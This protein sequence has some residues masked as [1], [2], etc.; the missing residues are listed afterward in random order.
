MEFLRRRDDV[1]D[2]DPAEQTREGFF[3]WDDQ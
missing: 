2:E 3:M 1:D